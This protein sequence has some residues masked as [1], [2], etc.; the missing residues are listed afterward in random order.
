MASK[1]N[2]IFSDNQL[3]QFKIDVKGFRDFLCPH[4]HAS[5]LMMEAKMV[6][7]CCA[8]AQDFS[9]WLPGKI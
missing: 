1:S 7:E 2:S 6:P 8:F 4:H 5:S 3:R 9:D